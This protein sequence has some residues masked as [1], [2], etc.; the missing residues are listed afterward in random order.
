MAGLN[1]LTSK[2]EKIVVI[3]DGMELFSMTMENDDLIA[4]MDA[5]ILGAIENA[6]DFII[7][8]DP[9]LLE[10]KVYDENGQEQPSEQLINHLQGA[11]K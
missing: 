2:G 3:Y 8:Y 1:V 10:I 11:L 5:A 7:D 9:D 6:I 4:L